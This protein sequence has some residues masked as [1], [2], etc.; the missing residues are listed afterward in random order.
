MAPRD[1][2]VIGNYAH[3][4]I[5][6]QRGERFS[7]LGGATAYM[8]SVLEA[9]EADYEV[10]SKVGKDFLYTNDLVRP[11]TVDETL[12]TTCFLDDFTSGRRVGT[13][14]AL[15]APIRAADL[16]TSARISIANGCAGEV[17]PEAVSKLRELSEVVVADLQSILRVLGPDGVIGL[18][19]LSKTN[20]PVKQIDFLK[21]SE[22]EAAFVDVDGPV[23]I[24]T[25]GNQGCEIVE[26]RKRTHVPGF[27][28]EE[29]DASGAGD[30]FLAGFAFALAKGFGVLEAARFANYCGSLA[31]KQTGIPKLTA[32][33]F[34]S[35]RAS[36]RR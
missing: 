23:L 26:G 18:V 15:C 6:T 36:L 19:P 21:G 22:E 14:K 34:T 9:L 20:H 4:E 2:L 11:S 16:T 35:M 32:A 28:A 17:L 31:V 29:I 7:A 33:D 13:V 12:P 25:K 1:L 10:V 8:C 27:P 30:C 5:I 24:I 3:D